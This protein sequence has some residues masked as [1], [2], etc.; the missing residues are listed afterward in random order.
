MTKF[1][2]RGQREKYTHGRKHCKDRGRNWSDVITSQ[3]TNIYQ[4]PPEAGQG[5]EGFFFKT[6]RDSLALLTP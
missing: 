6:C 3:G 2:K 4:H 5:K 1:F